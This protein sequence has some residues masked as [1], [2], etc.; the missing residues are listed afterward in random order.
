MVFGGLVA[1]K[2]LFPNQK[3]GKV[4]AKGKKESEHMCWELFK[5]IQLLSISFILQL[6][7]LRSRKVKLH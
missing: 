1:K 7:T 4:R 2:E 5:K 3:I 6:R